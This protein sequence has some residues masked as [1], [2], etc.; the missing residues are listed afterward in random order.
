MPL[1]KITA[2][3]DRNFGKQA[4]VKGM[5][6]EVSTPTTTPPLGH[7]QYDQQIKSLFMSKYGIDLDVVK[8]Q[9]NASYF[10]CEKL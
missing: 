2:K 8:V 1:W 9:P 4:M 10:I 3:M 6:I 5:S 7:K